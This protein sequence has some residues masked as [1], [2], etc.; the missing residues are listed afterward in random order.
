MVEG[1]KIW[2][3][4]IAIFLIFSSLIEIIVPQKKYKKYINLVLSLIFILIVL[5]PIIKFQNIDVNINKILSENEGEIVANNYEL[6]VAKEKQNEL[7]TQNYIKQLKSQIEV[8]M[9]EGGFYIQQIDIEIFENIEEQDYGQIKQI[10]LEISKEKNIDDKIVIKNIII[11]EDIKD[12]ADIENTEDEKKIVEQI[13][14][15]YD[16]TNTQVFVKMVK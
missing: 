6:G 14:S 5:E 15:Y 3:R 8:L 9:N 11:E 16:I 13:S 1:I 12:K 4:N 10:N 7:V 2:I